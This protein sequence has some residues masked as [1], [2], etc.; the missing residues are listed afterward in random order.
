MRDVARVFVARQRECE[1]ENMDLKRTLLTLS[2]QLKVERQRAD[3]AE[4]KTREV[5]SLFKSANEA[6][7]VAEQD[8]EAAVMD[9]RERLRQAKDKSRC[10]AD[11]IRSAYAWMPDDLDTVYYTPN[12]NWDPSLPEHRWDNHAGLVT[13]VGDAA[14]PMTYRTCAHA[15]CFLLPLSATLCVPLTALSPL[16]PWTRPRPAT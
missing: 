3:A 13:L 11:P 10:F 4:H 9:P 16:I 6:K 8:A 12:A 7:A 14:H 15:S 5:L 2:E 1:H